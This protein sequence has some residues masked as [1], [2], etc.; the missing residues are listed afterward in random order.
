MA[1]V[2]WGLAAVCIHFD[3]GSVTAGLRGD[4]GFVLSI[5]VCWL[6]IWL[7]CRVARLAPHQIPI[8]CL[9]V[10]GDAM[11]IDGAALRWFHGVY[12]ADD[13][14][15]RFGAAWL[16]WGYG[17]SAWIVLLMANRTS[18]RAAGVAA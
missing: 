1:A 11:M 14:V 13:T 9:V 6:S 3:P 15:A 18:R 2:F 7:A 5:P 10:L 4:I 17:I 12:A 16:L 8:G